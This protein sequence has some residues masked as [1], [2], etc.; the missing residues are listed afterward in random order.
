[1]GPGRVWIRAWN[2]DPRSWIEGVEL[3]RCSRDAQLGTRKSCFS[4]NAKERRSRAEHCGGISLPPRGSQRQKTRQKACE[5]TW[6][7]THA[8]LQ[9]TIQL[10]TTSR[11]QLYQHYMALAGTT[12]RNDSIA[13]NFHQLSPPALS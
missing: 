4:C 12:S 10:P 6:G 7:G 2:E 13:I 3:F 11:Q 9:W 1:M 8:P 5:R